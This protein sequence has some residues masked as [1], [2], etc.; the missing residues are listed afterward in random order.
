MQKTKTPA[1]KKDAAP[2]LIQLNEMTDAE[3]NAE[4]RI[5][6]ELLV[7][8]AAQALKGK[9]RPV[10]ELIADYDFR[11]AFEMQSAADEYQRILC[12]WGEKAI[13]EAL[14]KAAGPKA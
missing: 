14:K 2:D 3:V 8:K 4:V 5:A 10:G 9:S 1:K 7:R 6:T 11:Y 13:R 12:A